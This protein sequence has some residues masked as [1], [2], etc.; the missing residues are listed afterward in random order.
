MDAGSMPLR[1]TTARRLAANWS[2]AWTPDRTPPDL[3]LPTGV[4]TASTMTASRMA[5]PQ[6]ELGNPT[7]AETVALVSWIWQPSRREFRHAVRPVPPRREAAARPTLL[8]RQ[9][10]AGHRGEVG[11]ARGP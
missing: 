10:P 5:A 1:S 9:R 11:A 7:D 4:R 8:G 6:I 3:P 2:T